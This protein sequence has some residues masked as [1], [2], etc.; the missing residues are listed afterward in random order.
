[1][2]AGRLIGLGFAV[3]LGSAMLLAP[4]DRLQAWFLPG[5]APLRAQGLSGTLSQGRV[6][7]LDVQGR[8]ALRQLDWTLQTW[9]LLLG[10]ASF[11]LAGGAD[12]MLLDGTAYV[13]PSGTLTLSDFRLASPLAQAL[14]AAGQGM[15]PVEGTFG[16]DIRR[17]KLRQ[18]WPEQAEGILSVRGLGWK[19]G[20]EPVLLGDYEA[21]LEN[22][23]AGI[24]LS[25]TTTAG[26]LL[27]NGTGQLGN[28]RSYTLD[29]Q[30]RPQPD[31]PPMVSNLVRNLG[32][33]DAQGWY[34]LRRRGQLAPPDAN[35]PAPLVD[36]AS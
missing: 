25:V 14:Q 11:R 10:R 19:L 12:G 29:L 22:E 2:K 24:K 32:Q 36:Q 17:L 34:H 31:A 20:R 4:A 30:M 7:Q 5:D 18:Q 3:F 6:T 21:R 15:L 27:V 28:D 33:P 23:T 16:A 9:Q 26:A 8:P 1:M 35:T 13:V